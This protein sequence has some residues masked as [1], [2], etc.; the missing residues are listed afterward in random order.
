MKTCKKC[1]EE[2]PHTAFHT[3]KTYKDGY[4]KTCIVCVKAKYKA[5]I[6][7]SRA[8]SRANYHKHATVRKE[9]SKKWKDNNELSVAA[10]DGRSRALRCGA[11]VPDNFELSSTVPFYEKARRLT[12]ETG[13]PHEVDHIVPCSK[14]GLH[15]PTN[16][17]VL[18]AVENNAKRTA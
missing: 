16:L 11:V 5:N 8:A 18:T 12:K 15:C 6:E 4:V 9:Q 1:N 10:N 2:L 13:V 14:G 3:N 7:E 17:Q